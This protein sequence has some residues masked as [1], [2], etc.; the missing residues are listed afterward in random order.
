MKL[1]VITCVAKQNMLNYLN[2]IEFHSF[3]FGFC[4]GELD[5]TLVKC[6]RNILV[7]CI[8]RNEKFLKQFTSSNLLNSINH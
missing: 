2:L 5:F 3:L 4:C 6:I 8:V 7:N 1:T